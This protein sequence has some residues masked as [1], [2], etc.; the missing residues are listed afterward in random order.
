M[1]QSIFGE[2][3]ERYLSGDRRNIVFN[4]GMRYLNKRIRKNVTDRIIMAGVLASLF[5][6]ATTYCQSFSNIQLLEMMIKKFPKDRCAYCQKGPCECHNDRREKIKPII[7]L[8]EQKLWGVNDWISN[9]R[10]VY[11]DKNR[12]NGIPYAYSRLSEERD[13]AAEVFTIDVQDYEITT[14]EWKQMLAG[15]FADI[16]AWIFALADLYNIDLDAAIWERY[17]G[18]C[19]RCKCRTCECGPHYRYKRSTSDHRMSGIG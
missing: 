1:L 16:F 11:G 3:Q 9:S 4:D 19:P 5:S 13:E 14:Y 2:R 15:E 7:G 18:I 6:R 10:V 8:P 17:P 12:L